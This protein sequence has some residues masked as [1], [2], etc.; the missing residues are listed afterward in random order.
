MPGGWHSAHDHVRDLP[1]ILHGM[2]G[3]LALAE[4]RPDLEPELDLFA[5]LKWGNDYFLSLQ[6]PRGFAYFGVYA[7]EYF[8]SYDWWD[9]ASYVLRT[10]PGPRYTQYMFIAAQAALARI[11]R[12]R[13][14]GYASLCLTAAERCFAY[15]ASRPGGDWSAEPNRYELGAG[16]YA[17]ALLFRATGADRYR[18]AAREF[19]A[20]LLRLQTARG[21]WPERRDQ[22]PDP[23]PDYNLLNARALYP[24]FAPIGLCEVLRAL[25]ADPEAPRWREALARFLQGF[26]SSYAQ[27]NAF[28]ILPHFVYRDPDKPRTRHARG[29]SYRYFIDPHTV[30]RCPG[31]KPIPWQTGNHGIVAGYGAALLAIGNL[32]QLP[33]AHLLAQRQLDWILGVNPFD[34]CH[35][36]GFGRNNPVTYPSLD[37]MPPVPDIVGA[38]LQGFVGDDSDTPA[39]VGGYY[40]N[41]EF[42]MPQHAWTVWLLAELSSKGQQA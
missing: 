9:S 31:T 27:A 18:S 40:S 34:A 14:P 6:D 11:Y 22:D 8:G 16:A 36:L 23:D 39:E 24:A 41:G 42:W 13:Q 29:E 1:E 37:F 4:A 2:F 19:A 28:G 12:Q 33:E 15:W 10:E 20:G 32:L 38:G 7:K 21:Y 3:L 5:E 35:V 26:G 17:T 25:P 30:L